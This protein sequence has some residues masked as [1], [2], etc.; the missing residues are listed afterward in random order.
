M[1]TAAT[2]HARTLRPHELDVL[3]RYGAGHDL[4]RIH[5][6]TKLPIDMVTAAVTQIASMNR[7]YARH[8]VQE[9]HRAAGRP[10]APAAAPAP[11][12]V[13]TRPARARPAS[14]SASPR[15]VLAAVPETRDDHADRAPDDQPEPPPHRDTEEAPP[16][17][18]PTTPRSTAPATAPA[19][20]PDAAPQ[21]PPV[22][23]PASTWASQ[24]IHT[25]E[26]LLTAS[27]AAGGQPARIAARIRL[28]LD[29]LQTKIAEAAREHQLR[30]AIAALEADL[31]TRRAE[32]RTLTGTA[33]APDTS[34][35]EEAR[36]ARAWAAA[37]GVECPD[38]GRVPGAVLEAYR[39]RPLPAGAATDDDP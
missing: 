20:A 18:P 39:N 25:V 34:A 13:K 12:A 32:L 23:D 17:P 14:S 15:P 29:D 33:P 10:S 5:R 2:T 3:A 1:T 16:M 19:S 11:R 37:N 31:A 9:H 26:D 6:D 4:A 8:L 22:T 27:D 38:R 36:A 21:N 28:L 7:Q 35:R 24:P 30:T